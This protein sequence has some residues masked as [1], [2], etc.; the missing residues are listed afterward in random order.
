M[1]AFG[2]ISKFSRMFIFGNC[3]TYFFKICLQISFK[4]FSIYFNLTADT[5]PYTRYLKL[6]QTAD[7]RSLLRADTSVLILMPLY[8][9]TKK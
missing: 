9:K 7:T 2:Y 6:I 5:L 8:R 4:L 1:S 3:N